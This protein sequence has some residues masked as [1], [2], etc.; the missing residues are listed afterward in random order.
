MLFN[1]IIFQNR[2]VELETPPFMEKS[3]FHFDYLNPSLTGYRNNI[4]II[5]IVDVLIL[6]GIVVSDMIV[7]ILGRALPM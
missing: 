7:A 1:K 4:F 3:N 5:A 2:F 6:I